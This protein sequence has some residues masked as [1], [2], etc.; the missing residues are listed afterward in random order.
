MEYF[1]FSKEFKRK[2]LIKCGYT[3]KNIKCWESFSSYHNDIDYVDKTI[4]IWVKGNEQIKENDHARTYTAF[5]L[6]SVF[7]KVFEEK[8]INLLI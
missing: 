8:L 5:E 1:D 3:T 2:F 7:K 6:D 4:E